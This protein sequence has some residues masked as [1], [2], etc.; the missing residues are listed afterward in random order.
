MTTRY[1]HPALIRHLGQGPH[2]VEASAGT[3]KTYL[4]EHLFVDLI[5]RHQTQAE[6]ILVVTFTEKA[7]AELTL[8]VRALVERLLQH[9]DT[10]ASDRDDSWILDDHARERLALTLRHFD[11][12]TIATLHGFCQ[13][14]LRDHAFVQGRL[15][16]ETLVNGK[17]SFQTVFHEVLRE[18]LAGDLREQALLATWIQE[19]QSIAAL[20]E[21]LYTCHEK[22]PAIL[23]PVLNAKRLSQALSD[24]ASHRRETKDL[25]TALRAVNVKG[26]ALK[27]KLDRWDKLWAAMETIAGEPIR[28]IGHD[29]LSEYL[30]T[31]LKNWPSNSSPT[32]LHRLGKALAELHAS[33]V[34]LKAAMAATFLQPIQERLASHRRKTGEVD[35]T[36][37]L[38]RVEQ[39]LAQSS[40]A[41]QALRT[42]LRER[43]HHALIDE[44]QDTDPVQWSIFRRLFFDSAPG[45][46]LTVIG[47]PKQAIYGFRG[48][49][50]HTYLEARAAIQASSGSS[51]H[52]TAN[53]RSTPALVAATNRLFQEGFFRPE[54]GMT[55]DHPVTAAQSE[56]RL[57]MRDGT[58]AAPVVVLHLEAPAEP[59]LIAPL[60]GALR[61]GIVQEIHR[62]I[63]P[64]CPLRRANRPILPSD[65]FIL[66]LTNHES[67]AIG[68]DLAQAGI[69]FAFF[70]QQDL[71]QSVEARDLLA[72][73]RA[74]CQPANR[75]LRARAFLTPFFDLRLEDV[76]RW[77]NGPAL[78]LFYRLLDLSR[79]GDLGF[80]LSACLYETGVIRRALIAPHGERALTNYLHL[81]ELLQAEWAKSGKRFPEL[82]ETF[83][84]WIHHGDFPSG[85]ETSM[86]R[87]ST[88][89]RAVQILTIHK[90]KGLEADFVFLYTGQGAARSETV[91]LYHDGP[92]R[93]A[94]IAPLDEIANA[95]YQ[96]ER[97]DEGAR[98]LYV[99][100]TRA[101]YRLYLPHY[102]ASARLDG[103]LQILNA[104]LDTVLTDPRDEFEVLPVS[105]DKSVDRPSPSGQTSPSRTI[106]EA[107]VSRQ[108]VVLSGARRGFW[109]TSYSSIKRA[110]GGFVPV[111]ESLASDHE[112]P[113]AP[114]KDELPPGPETGVFLHRLLEIM[115]V[116][117][118]AAL[119]PSA[120]LEEQPLL[121]ALAETERQHA[122]RPPAHL[123]PALRLVDRAYRTPL[124]LGNR[125]IPGIAHARTLLHEVEFLFPIPEASHALLGNPEGQGFHIE[126]GLVKGFI[127]LVFEFDD[128]IY[129]CDWKSDR[130][131]RWDPETLANHVSQNYD[132]QARL[133]T[134]ATLRWLG[135]RDDSTYQKRIGGILYC[136]L[137]GLSSKDDRQGIH[138]HRPTWAQI[139]DWERALVGFNFGVMA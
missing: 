45:R 118:I 18:T 54:S 78:Y 39:A 121:R 60:R 14:V 55:Y 129:I 50:V 27:A 16:N 40:P 29:P 100:L 131:P 133:Y 139:L 13:R 108:P 2:V 9:T 99:G 53:Y 65:I 137:R 36:D 38:T 74:L 124:C 7:T 31:L 82:V 138:F 105:L 10:G 22:S 4:L 101:R 110:Q 113:Q 70:K 116:Q 32:T 127:D 17:D 24:L 109:V 76:A 41:G 136:F 33:L 135:I 59:V 67:Q 25:E 52:L 11:R 8:R 15:W 81:A 87:L 37:L 111:E 89:S 107:Q 47:D 92:S 19:G 91:Y 77:K 115:P 134:L 61:A 117:H 93:I 28:A 6:N 128:Q 102:P 112:I 103:P 90:A 75:G 46:S 123:I 21:L 49:D 12:V 125:R 63:T 3:G 132:M 72:L 106:P 66:T 68:Q 69:P 23:R 26:P 80:F 84:A 1:S 130:L 88:D 122:G 30:K 43:Y 58:A 79:Q 20:G 57:E 86:Q 85:E 104:R 95:R 42:S 5:L 62:L 35:F 34:P 98:L 71:L 120:P 51:Y 97:T 48:A 64:L 94:H 73:W 119:D 44:F 56:I 126:R 96:A 83:A 114:E